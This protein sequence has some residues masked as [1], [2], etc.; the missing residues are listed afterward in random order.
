VKKICLIGGEGIGIEVVNSA[1]RILEELNLSNVE[2]LEAYAGVEGEKKLGS[3]FPDETKEAIDN[4]DA[5]LFGATHKKAQ[6]VLLYLRYGLDNFANIRPCRLYK[7]IKSP[8]RD[9]RDIDFIIVRENLEGLYSVINVGEWNIKKLVKR[10]ILREDK[11]KKF[12]HESSGY[13]ATKII[14][15]FG[16]R[17]IAKLACEKTLERKNSGYPGKLTIVHKSNVMPS[18]DGLFKKEAYS[19]AQEYI[20]KYGIVVNDFYVD[21]MA[22]RLVRFPDNQDI[23][24]TVNEYGDI[25]SDLAAELVGGLGLAPSGCIGGK[26]PYFE[27]VHG[28]A[29]DIAGL[30][31][32]NPL[33]AILS[34]KML[35]K[36]FGFREAD[37]LEKSVENYFLLMKDVSRNWQYLPK[38]LVSKEFQ[39]NNKFGKTESITN[40]IIDI[41]NGFS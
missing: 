36:Y 34:L 10:G 15:E 16:T 26:I 9:V 6:G 25:L 39:V 23:I 1:K 18:T 31:I 17:R 40:K 11:Y 30:G 14:T 37:L 7:G 22:R 2:I 13:F 3:T 28:S 8:L 27:P 5:V 4:S 19:T 38:D 24:L 12:F 35:L 29:P 20:E 21:D 41:L 33:A 32:A